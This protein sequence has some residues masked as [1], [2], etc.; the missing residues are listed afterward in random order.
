MIKQFKKEHDLDY[1]KYWL[2]EHH[3]FLY[4]Q[5][6]DC[7]LIIVDEDFNIRLYNCNGEPYKINT[8]LGITEA[9]LTTGSQLLA[10]YQ[11]WL[12]V[13]K[14]GEEIIDLYDRIIK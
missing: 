8:P 6:Y 11:K 4:E 7:N 9:C 10:D 1:A 5:I 2:Y 3:I 12:F 14:H 13:K